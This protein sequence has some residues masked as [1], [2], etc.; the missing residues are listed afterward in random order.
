[1]YHII[2]NSSSKKGKRAV[3]DITKELTKRGVEFEF[4][5]TQYAKH[6][7]VLAAEVSQAGAKNIIGVGGDGTFHEI[8]NGI[9]NLSEVNLGFIPLGSGNDF[10]ACAKL[11]K[12][13]VKKALNDILTGNIKKIDYIQFEDGLRCLNIAGTGLDVEV[14]KNTLAMRRLKGKPM[15]LWGLIRALKNFNPYKINVEIDGQTKSYEC[16]MVGVAN[17]MYFGGGMNLSPLSN[18]SDGKLNVVIIKMVK[19]SQIKFLLPKFLRGSHINMY[20]SEHYVV[21]KVKI[22]NDQSYR[23]EL[24]GEI[25]S[26]L[27]FDCHVVPGGINMLGR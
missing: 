5:F 12:G 17:G 16:I 18:I 6:A 15:Y 11:K 14:L 23:V 13:N 25:Y 7:K 19:R 3:K 1:M 22:T 26:N 20:F 2:I 9:Q 21:D 27:N 10:A 4:H 8:I 24:D